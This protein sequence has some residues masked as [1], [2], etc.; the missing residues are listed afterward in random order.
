MQDT[1]AIAPDVRADIEARLASAASEDGVRLLMAVESGSRAWGFPS[2]DSDYDVRTLYVRPRRDYLALKPVR[3]VV[4]RP[5]V[6]DID[7]NGCDIR[8]ALGLMLKHNAVLSEWLES[9]IRYI[10]DDPVVEQLADLASRHFSPRGYALHYASL[11]RS[12]VDRWLGPNGEIAVKRYFYALRPALSVRALRL[13][14]SRRPPMS[15]VPLMQAAD[16]D[17]VLVDQVDELIAQKAKT[18][19]AGNTIRLPDIERLVIGELERAGEVPER[20][21]KAN[22]ADEAEALFLELVEKE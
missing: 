9:P 8:K 21:D 13:D 5:I 12:S 15:M 10:V 7:L 14:P 1:L 2:P 19:E 22:F 16:L 17:G 20:T 11:G 6:D 4:E 3:D 18:N